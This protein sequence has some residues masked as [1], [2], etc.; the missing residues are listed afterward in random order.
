MATALPLPLSTPNRNL[1]RLTIVRGITWTGFLMAIIV[2]I[3][4]LA[5]NLPVTAVVSVVIA[6]G[7]LNIATWWRLGRPR[8][9]THIEYLAHL[10]ADITGLTLL[11]YFSGGSTNPFITYYL[12]P[13]TIAAATL[14]WRHAWII[15]ACAMGGYTFLMFSTTP[16]RS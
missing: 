16:F 4:L 2:G 14:P 6:M 5:F 3:E 1:V 7:M 10:L 11:F 13:V 9:V 15:A 12:V 8:A